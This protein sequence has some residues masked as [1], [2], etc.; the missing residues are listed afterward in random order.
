MPARPG[1]GLAVG[2]QQ[3]AATTLCL[4]SGLHQW[5]AAAEAAC[6]VGC[7]Q[8]ACWAGGGCVWWH[9]AMCACGSQPLMPAPQAQSTAAGPRAA[10]PAGHRG[11]SHLHFCS[12]VAV[13]CGELLAA[14]HRG[15]VDPPGA[16]LFTPARLHWHLHGVVLRGMAWHGKPAG[17]EHSTDQHA[18]VPSV[19][20]PHRKPHSHPDRTRA[21]MTR[22]SG[23][24]DS[25]SPSMPA[26]P[27]ARE[28]CC[29]WA[30][31]R[32]MAARWALRCGP[33]WLRSV[34][35]QL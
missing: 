17:A 26:C 2:L 19:S 29:R 1:E 5:G 21:R 4:A 9:A 3:P 10:D 31:G 14:C 6:P 12:A 16:K 24:G 34:R 27:R 23:C 8:A 7:F 33:V 15:L 35:L 20:S 30:S 28:R 18:C 22:A 13:Q 11:W 32:G 25:S